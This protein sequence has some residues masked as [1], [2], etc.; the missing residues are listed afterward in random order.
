MNFATHGAGTVL[1]HK[2]VQKNNFFTKLSSTKLWEKLKKDPQTAKYLTMINVYLS[3]GYLFNSTGLFTI[4]QL[5]KN[6]P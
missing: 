2:G 3:I 1:L 4:D 6:N 5:K